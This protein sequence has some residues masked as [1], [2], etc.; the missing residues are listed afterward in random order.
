MR[1]HK[2]LHQTAK[3]RLPNAQSYPRTATAGDWISWADSSGSHNGRVLGVIVPE[4][5]GLEWSG[6]RVLSVLTFSDDMTFTM[7][8]WVHPT[9]V[10]CSRRI[11]EKQRTEYA[12]ILD[13]NYDHRVVLA[14]WG[15]EQ[16]EVRS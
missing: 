13:P 2:L 10:T 4:R 8:R 14:T 16:S 12:R 6:E 9:Q 3:V 7:I 15:E 11:S 5:D 1:Q